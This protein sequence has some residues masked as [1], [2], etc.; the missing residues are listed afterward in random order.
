[1]TGSKN[2]YIGSKADTRDHA[3]Q[4][5]SATN[6][7]VIG[8]DASG[9]GD[10]TATIGN[11]DMTGFYVGAGLGKLVIIDNN[12]S[13]G[14]QSLLHNTG[15]E[16]TAMG[17]SALY[18]TTS[19]NN[20]TALGNIAGYSLTT[21]DNNVHIGYNTQASDPSAT[22]EIVIGANAIGNGDNTTT[23]GNTTTTMTYID[24]SL[25]TTGN[26]HSDG[27]ITHGGTISQT[28]DERVKRDIQPTALGLDFIDK[29]SPVRYR[30]V[31]P[32]DYPE[33][34]LDSKFKGDAPAPRPPDDDT[35]YD[36]LIAQEVE[37]AIK[38][39][40][41]EWSGHD[42][43]AATGKQGLQYGLL[44]VPLIN[45]VKELKQRIEV[46]ENKI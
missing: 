46:L 4:N 9:N 25:N 18:S 38:D 32:A 42:V 43:D 8:A 45:A 41:V 16:N 15:N 11:T 29:L 6:E 26:I 30:R 1:V 36:G 20:N 40:G 22:N 17:C 21:G 19:G 37:A 28:S 31:N 33:P 14:F 44:V 27:N 34:L 39:L 24:S 13:V 7:I 35:A 10:H 12:T 3:S 2:I 23:I 5:P